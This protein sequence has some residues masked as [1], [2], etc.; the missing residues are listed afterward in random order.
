M[1]ELTSKLNLLRI[2]HDVKR[3]DEIVDNQEVVLCQLRSKESDRWN[4]RI[5]GADG[6][7]I[8]FGVC[9]TV[10]K[11][12]LQNLKTEISLGK[13]NVSQALD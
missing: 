2:R 4:F 6:P 13:R 8:I 1:D 10:G 9:S 11:W 5:Y 12:K 7:I 3:I